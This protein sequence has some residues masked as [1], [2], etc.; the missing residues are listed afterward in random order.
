MLRFVPVLSA[1]VI[2]ILGP[3][4][5]F[6]A[7][8]EYTEA[9]AFLGDYPLSSVIDFDVDPTG[10]PLAAGTAIDGQYQTLGVDLNPFNGGTP[11]TRSSFP[12]LPS[13]S[14]PNQVRT[15]P[16]LE[17]GGGFEVVFEQPVYAVGLL[18]GD[19]QNPEFLGETTMTILGQAGN[20]IHTSFVSTA[21]GDSPSQWKFFGLRSSEGICSMQIAA[22]SGDFVTYDDLHFCVVPEPASLSLL[23]IGLCFVTRRCNRAPSPRRTP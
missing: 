21:V 23:A 14:M 20:E 8:A 1:I 12:S 10:S 22:G 17:G 18:F 4:P 5:S 2:A 15:M 16:G 11:E 6:G 13:P 3:L 7:V 19:I 9:E